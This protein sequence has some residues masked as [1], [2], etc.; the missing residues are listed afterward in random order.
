MV[1]TVVGG[2]SDG[3]GE[4]NDLFRRA[5][6]LNKECILELEQSKDKEDGN[7]KMEGKDNSL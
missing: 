7:V 2:A 6:S 3:C 4:H 1:K 5:L